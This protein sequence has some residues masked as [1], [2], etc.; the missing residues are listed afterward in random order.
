[1]LPGPGDAPGRAITGVMTLGG[2]LKAD[3]SCIDD[4]HAKVRWDGRCSRQGP[5]NWALSWRF[6]WGHVG[7][8][9]AVSRE[10]AAWAVAGQLARRRTLDWGPTIP[11]SVETYGRYKEGGA[12]PSRQARLSPNCWPSPRNR[13]FVLM[14]CLPAIRRDMP[15]SCVRCATA[16]GANS[17]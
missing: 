17:R 7:N 5:P 14:A 2:L 6:R 1:M 11:P 9:T 8:W 13:R 12:E 10:L 16:V 15:T 4:A 3:G